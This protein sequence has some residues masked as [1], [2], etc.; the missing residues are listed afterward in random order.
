MLP[1]TAIFDLDGLLVDTEPTY[2]QMYREILKP[3]GKDMSLADYA[4]R[5]SGG[6]RDGNLTRLIADYGLSISLE[7][8]IERQET[9]RPLVISATAPA[10][11]GAAELLGWLREHGVGIMLGTSC[12]EE[13]A[14]GLLGSCGLLGFFDGFAYGP[15]V[16][17][18]KPEPDIFLLAARRAGA[19]PAE[20]VVFEDSESGV[21]AAHAAGMRVVCVPDMRQ[22]TD[23]VRELCWKVLGFLGEAIPAFEILVTSDGAR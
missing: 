21:C 5:Y 20:C 8:A 19:K 22:P 13:R 3:F 12:D 17:R 23:E 9:V 1:T 18:S 11:S 16:R 2:W 4:Q 14:K 10:K 15:E 7:D 6:T